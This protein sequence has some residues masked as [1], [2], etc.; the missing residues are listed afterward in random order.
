M[1]GIKPSALFSYAL[2]IAAVVLAAVLTALLHPIMLERATFLFFII[3]VLFSA[4][5]GGHGPGLLAV[6]LGAWVADWFFLAPY[7]S[8]ALTD[9]RSAGPVTV[10]L[11]AAT[12]V[13]VLIAEG[14]RA[15][16]Q[17]RKLSR[18]VEQSPA[19]VIIT[20]TEGRIEYVNPKFSQ[21]TGYTLEE[22]KGKN[23]R[24]LKSG[25]TAPEEYRRLWETVNS[26]GEWRGEF[27][28][29]RKSGE[30]FWEVAS[31]SPIRGRAGVITHFLAVK[32]DISERKQAEA[33]IQSL[34]KL[35]S[36]NPNPILRI[37]RN[38]TLLY[39]NDSGVCGLP[40]WNL[41]TGKPAPIIFQNLVSQAMDKRS[42]QVVE[43]E[44]GGRT[45]LFSVVPVV[46]TDY[47]NLYGRDMT[48]RVQA[49]KALRRSHDLLNLTGQMAGVG[50]WE[51]DLA[52]QSVTWTQEVYRIHEVDPATRVNLADAINFYAPEARP[53]IAAAV[54]AC[55]DSGT[56]WDLE[57]PLITAQGRHIW[58]RAQGTAEIQG[59]RAVR[60]YGAF[61]D[62]TDRK[63]AIVAL[64]EANA[65]FERVVEHISDALIQDDLDGRV[66]FANSRF[67]ELFNLPETNPA[68]LMLEDYIAPEWREFL[69]NRNNRRVRGEDV[70]DQFEY[71]GLWRDGSTMWLEVTVT[72]VIENG[73]IIGTQSAIR[74]IS[75]RKRAELALRLQGAALDAAANAIIITDRNGTIEWVNPA[76]TELT[77]YS[78][79]EA[80]GKNPGE[81][82]KSG[83]H[84]PA[85]YKNL[86]DTLLAGRPWHGEMINRR[87][88]GNRHPEEQT[89]TPVKDAGGEITHFVA[90]KRD[91]TEAK[92]L[93]AQFLQ[94]QKMEV[95]GRLAGGIA[96]DFNNLLTF[97]IGIADL[98]LTELKQGEP[99]R[100]DLEEILLAGKRAAALTQQLLTF[101][102]RQVTKFEPISLNA[103][104]T[105]MQSMLPRLIGEDVRLVFKLA[106]AL[107]TV[108]AD[109]SQLGQVIL[110]LAVNARDAMPTG[111]TLT[112]ETA[113]VALDDA[114]AVRHLSVR[115]GPHVM[116]AIS[117][118]GVG[119]DAET[120]ERIFEPFFTT[121]GPAKGTGL[122]LSTVYG[123]V[124]QAGGSIWVYSEI[125]LGTTFKVYL[126]RLEV[127][128]R[129]PEP[130]LIVRE[131][132]G[133]ETILIVEDED[134]VR[135]LARRFLESAGYRVLTAS[136]AGEALLSVE[137]QEG[138]I[139]LVLMDVVMP[140]MNG[141][142]LAERLAASRSEIKIL[143]TSGYTDDTIAHHGVLVEGVDFISKPYTLLELLHKVRAVLDAQG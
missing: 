103:V 31:I 87:K 119:M 133:S 73:R 66:V 88:D 13:S 41:R 37:A 48:A 129:K 2:A 102:R 71:K 34:A 98:A 94:A 91:L 23:P 70:P 24:I 114:H 56:P 99:L 78:A 27:H 8:L 109:F 105:D 36:E 11:L 131:V 107:G 121:K 108:K 18:A 61:Q 58:V 6:V 65:R 118:T 135:G 45:Y 49:E 64:R 93:E 132:Q 50:G 81:L 97:I 76:F 42:T 115:P 123:I 104:V 12:V 82:V 47:V 53:V 86:W 75:E 62:I 33:E 22:V 10:F 100:A 137:G 19:S 96:H 14:R 84:D 69:R 57:L 46:G 134:S 77:G 126:P 92:R 79:E 40:D 54:Q 111:G 9:P 130:A 124:R 63:Q 89:I 95:V 106:E 90:I 15:E 122:G 68:A 85:F 80:T 3:A 32:E 125:G 116:L 30:L 117:D 21:A 67:F 128:A 113:N 20:D 110:N 74:D 4:W 5:R 44:H 83:V 139:H 7:H 39:I 72:K 16:A 141:P 101:S 136:N 127:A 17:L 60:L 25:E 55:I 138:P 1:R 51:L 38:G 28:N 35:A 29:K 112:I 52:T 120:R 26:G 140:G 143:Y 142:D 59:G 43:L